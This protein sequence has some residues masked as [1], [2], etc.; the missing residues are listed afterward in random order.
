MKE[1]IPA[2]WAVQFLSGNQWWLGYGV[3]SLDEEMLKT[4]VKM[5]NKGLTN[6][7]DT[8]AITNVYIKYNLFFTHTVFH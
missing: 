1:V 8:I 5:T 2:A 3:V 7:L 4:P 6:L